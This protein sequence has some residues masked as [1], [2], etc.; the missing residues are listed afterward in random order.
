M[1][2]NKKPLPWH[3]V[4]EQISKEMKWLRAAIETSPFDKEALA[5]I[6]CRECLLR[7]IAILIVDGTIHA[8]ELKRSTSLESF[9]TDKNKHPKQKKRPQITHGADWHNATME[10]I[11]NHFLYQ[12]YEVVREPNLDW[13]RADL[14]IYK[15]NEKNLYVEVGTTSIFKLLVNLSAMRNCVYLIIPDDS[16]LIEFTCREGLK[17]NPQKELLA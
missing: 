17:K 5:P 1:A 7:K 3:V 9:W 15:N 13:G 6:T 12:N 2:K 14:G 4:E 10:K 8:K 11:E 16:R